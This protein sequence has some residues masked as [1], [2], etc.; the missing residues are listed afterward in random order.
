MTGYREEFLGIAGEYQY[1]PRKIQAVPVTRTNIKEVAEWCGGTLFYTT[2]SRFLIVMP[3]PPVSFLSDPTNDLSGS[4]GD[5]IY[6]EAGKFYRLPSE[7]FKAKFEPFGINE[8]EPEFDLDFNQIRFK[9]EVHGFD[10]I[11]PEPSD[12]L[13]LFDLEAVTDGYR[14]VI[15]SWPQYDR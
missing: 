13:P 2:P 1:R 7:E 14:K 5:W 3:G 15:A 4:Y 12:D 9:R 6:E 11:E 8:P 10:E